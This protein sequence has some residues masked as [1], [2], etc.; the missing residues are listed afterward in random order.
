MRAPLAA[1]LLLLGAPGCVAGNKL[2]R[3]ESPG[4][5]VEK[6]SVEDVPVTGSHVDVD[7]AGTT[8]E[9]ELIAVDPTDFWILEETPANASVR[10][11]CW[12]QVH[13]SQI[14]SVHIRLYD[15]HPGVNAALSVLGLASTLANGYYLVF[16]APIWIVGG[17]FS[18]VSAAQARHYYVSPQDYWLLPQFAR[19]PG[20]LPAG[21]AACPQH[22]PAPP[23]AAPSTGVP[24]ST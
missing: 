16:T 19:F 17:T 14:T 1:A 4:G 2:H 8:V 5:P 6:L 9:G 15:T 3:A 21:R 23:P 13:Q 18:I 12:I 10:S 22:P 7:A 20:G 11:P 24:A